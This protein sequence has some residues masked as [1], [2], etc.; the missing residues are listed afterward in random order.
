MDILLRALFSSRSAENIFSA[1]SKTI[2]VPFGALDLFQPASQQAPEQRSGLMML[3]CF[4]DTYDTQV[5]CLLICQN[6]KQ[7]R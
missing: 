1:I 4:V 2:Q 7:T 3:K 5:V 6:G